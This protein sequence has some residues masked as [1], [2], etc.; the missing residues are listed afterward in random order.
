ML[1]DESA[2]TFNTHRKT[3][4]IRPPSPSGCLDIIATLGQGSFAKLLGSAPLAIG[5]REKE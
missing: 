3:M 2:L 5:T 4:T 1:A